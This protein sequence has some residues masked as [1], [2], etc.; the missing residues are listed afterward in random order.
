MKEYIPVKDYVKDKPVALV[1]SE[2]GVATAIAC[3]KLAE[4]VF[5]DGEPHNIK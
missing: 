5:V 2:Y 3:G 4:K 1:R